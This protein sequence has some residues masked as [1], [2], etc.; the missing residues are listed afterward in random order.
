M[1]F[2]FIIH[3][4]ETPK[5]TNA[6]VYAVIKIIQIRNKLQTTSGPNIYVFTLQQ[7]KEP[8]L[9]AHVAYKPN[10]YI[11]YIPNDKCK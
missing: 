3:R 1:G 10:N 6:R 7:L 4:N 2:V 9:I 8:Y 5:T 11:A